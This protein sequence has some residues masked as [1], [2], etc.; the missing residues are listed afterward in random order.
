MVETK[1][2]EKNV[3]SLELLWNQEFQNLDA[4]VERENIREDNL[5][6]TAKLFAENAK[7]NQSNLKELVNQFSKELSDWEKT[8]RE[9]LLTATINLQTFLPIKSYEEINDELDNLHN[10]SSEFITSPLTKFEN[11][12]YVDQYV[13]AIEKYIDFRRNNRNWYIKNVKETA[14]IIQTNQYNFFKIITKQVRNVFL[15]FNRYIEQSNEITK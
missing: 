15:P 10:K 13:A 7:R 4:W 1:E 5:L 14:S 3:S 11:S 6:K 8:S 2:I 12:K 9:E